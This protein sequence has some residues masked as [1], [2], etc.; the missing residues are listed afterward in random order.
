M[1]WAPEE[2]N[3]ARRASP[4]VYED[5]SSPIGQMVSDVAADQHDVCMVEEET[6]GQASRERGCEVGVLDVLKGSERAR[7]REGE[8][9]RKRETAGGNA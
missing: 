2:E 5:R 6:Q 4:R 7:E 1:A 9:E 8:R 3:S